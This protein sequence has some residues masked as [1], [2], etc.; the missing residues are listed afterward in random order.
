MADPAP[1]QAQLG[2]RAAADAFLRRPRSQVLELALR[3]AL[4]SWEAA[5]A[6]TGVPSSP[7]AR[8]ALAARVA[9]TAAAAAAAPVAPAPPPGLLHQLRLLPR[10]SVLVFVLGALLG[11]VLSKQQPLETH[12]AN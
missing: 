12:K 3:A 9:A 1:V 10:L 5:V 4:R 11:I 8:R 6:A 2:V 7:G